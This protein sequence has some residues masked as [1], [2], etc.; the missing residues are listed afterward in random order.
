MIFTCLVTF[1]PF[2]L[3][4]PHLFS[5]RCYIVF[6]VCKLSCV[7]L[8]FLFS[9]FWYFC[10]AYFFDWIYAPQPP[11]QYKL[12]MTD[13]AKEEV[14]VHALAAQGR[15]TFQ[16]YWPRM[17]ITR[18]TYE[19]KAPLMENYTGSPETY[20]SFLTLYSLTL[21]CSLLLSPLSAPR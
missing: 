2:F 15:L 17:F 7:F 9:G 14:F 18:W 19:S 4:K 20:Y 3:F 13:W 1:L 5:F 16:F 10:F 6:V 12:A 11:L 21:N 8:F